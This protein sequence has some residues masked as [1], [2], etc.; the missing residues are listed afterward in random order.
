MCPQEHTRVILLSVDRPR[1]HTI[2]TQ[3]DLWDKSSLELM[4]T[5]RFPVMNYREPRQDRKVATVVDGLGAG[6]I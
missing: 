1:K 2:V 5:V 3:V 4:V 6:V